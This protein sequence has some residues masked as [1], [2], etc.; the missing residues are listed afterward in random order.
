MILKVGL[1]KNTQE[2]AALSSREREGL[3][4]TIGA[5][6]I[7]LFQSGGNRFKKGS[8][9]SV[10]AI[11]EHLIGVVESTEGMGNRSLRSR[12]TEA[13]ELVKIK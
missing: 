1:R 4:K 2:I 12:I 10:N 11:S 3:L 6:S 5:L 7:A 8:D 13:L 9:I